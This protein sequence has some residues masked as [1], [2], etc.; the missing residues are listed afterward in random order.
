MI[1]DPSTYIPEAVGYAA[2]TADRLSQSAQEA[3]EA[4]AEAA[5]KAQIEFQKVRT[6]LARVAARTEEL[7]KDN[8]W[9]AAGTMLGVGILLGAVGYRLFSPKPTLAQY[10]GV[11]GLPDSAR[12]Q[13]KSFNKS[14]KKYF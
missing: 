10:L 13:F 4:A 11:A 14:F 5:R 7:A 1:K 9:T 8:P 3:K 2:E 12:S 6:E